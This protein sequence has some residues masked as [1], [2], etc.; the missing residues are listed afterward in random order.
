MIRDLSE[1]LR[2]ILTQAG[3][4][5]ELAAAQIAFDRPSDSFN[6]PQT[7]ISL[8]LHEIRE[9]VS[10]RDNE[11]LVTRNRDRVVIARPP[12][13]VACS[14]LVTAW[15]VGGA[16]PALQEHRLLSQTLA[17]LARYPAIPRELAQGALKQQEPLVPLAAS[18]GDATKNT[19][20]LWSALGG[21]LRASLSVSATISLPIFPHE[22]A[23]VVENVAVGLRRR[24]ILGGQ[25]K[26]AAGLPV[27]G[28]TVAMVDLAISTLT[29]SDGRFLLEG[30]PTGRSKLEVQG[31]GAASELFVELPRDEGWGL[32]IRL[33]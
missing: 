20:E 31:V 16:E 6:P 17:V 25:V 30:L 4:P 8:Y 33:H 14:Y 13:R 29:N 26:D 23:P 2:A 10:R 22:E 15:V 9:D 27:A 19:S 5:P 1:T 24:W 11:Q 28:A 7:T 12:R 18:E 3:L 21:R 32:D